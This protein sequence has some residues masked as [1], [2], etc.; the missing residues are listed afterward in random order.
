V[1]WIVVPTLLVLVVFFW[2]F[3]AYVST[4]IPPPD[5]YQIE[6]NAQKW[7]WSFAYPNGTQT[8]GEI[9][10]PEGQPIKL[11]MSSKDVLHSFY[12][13]EFRIKHD[14]LPNRFTTVWFEAPRRG[15]YQVVCTEYCGTDHSNMGAK[16]RVVGRQEFN[17]FLRGEGPFAP[18]QDL[19]PAELGESLYTGRGC[20]ACH[21]IDGSAGVGPSWLGAWG[22]PRPGSE[23]GSVD[24]AYVIQSVLNPNAYMAPGFAGG[25][26]AYEGQLDE[27]QIRAIAAYMRVLNGAGLPADTS[28][29]ASDSTA[30]P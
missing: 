17:A 11:V 2:G 6:V 13:P 22:A 10:V 27:D 19:P 15:V 21:S 18:P 4:H 12:V 9:V 25:M 28:L 20:Q 16:I 5:A 24:D 14:V 3:R 23:T 1:S 29:A 8:F 7:S 26:P 30:T